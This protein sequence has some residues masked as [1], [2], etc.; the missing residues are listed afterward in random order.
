LPAAANP[1]RFRVRV[2]QRS[3]LRIAY[4]RLIGGY[5]PD[6]IFAGYRK[7]IDWG[8]RHCVVPRAT[9]IGISQD[10]PD[11][12]PMAKYRFDWCLVLPD[13]MAA[14]EGI[15]SA[16]IPAGFFAELHCRGDIQK[17]DR[18][19]RHLFYRWLPR[20]GL[21][22]THGPAMEVFRS[23]P[24]TIENWAEFDLDCCIPVRPIRPR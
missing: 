8:L 3:A 22:P 1:D 11:I 19:W 7:I 2:R 15:S 6:K 20:S 9:L 24:T 12:T 18:A 14:D 17:V 5:Q 21:E 13:G 10:D 16:T 4:V 23:Y